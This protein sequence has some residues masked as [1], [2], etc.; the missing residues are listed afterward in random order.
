MDLPALAD[1]TLVARHGGFGRAA[2]AS[3]RP[4]ATLSRRVAELEASLAL[5]LFERGARVLTLTE[6]GRAL[7]ERA[8][9]LLTELDE[10]AAA[11]AA[12]GARA[13][14]RLRISAPLLFSQVAM[15]RVAA[16]FAL[17]Y[18]EVRLS[19]TTEDRAV[20]MIEEGYDLVIRVNPDR[21]ESLVGRAFLR[22]RMVVVAAPGL[23]RPAEGACVPAVVRAMEDR[24][25][26][27]LADGASLAV[28]PVLALSS[29]V[30]I[31][32][33][34]RTGLGAARLPVSL[35]AHDLAAGRLVSWGDMAGS[36]IA[37]WALY[38]SRRLLSARVSAFLEHLR[39]TFPTGAPEELAAYLA[40]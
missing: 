27:T 25:V 26:W 21:D 22:D 30:M 36:D 10:T 15:G 31:R 38:P 32:D 6:E 40:D 23:P 24:V 18:P 3:G 2:R 35:V 33:A 20:D 7:H 14:G 19:V 34:V 8:G 9:A 29:L 1:F 4:K 17:K 12:G 39:E 37:L 5:R 11:I 13:R 16:D 28:A